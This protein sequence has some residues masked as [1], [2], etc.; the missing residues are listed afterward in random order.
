MMR[1]RQLLLEKRETIAR[2]WLEVVLATYPGSSAAI[3]G[4]EKDPFANP[5]GHGLRVGTEH[6]LALLLDDAELEDIGESLHGIMKIRA[7]QQFPP[8]RAVAF[9]FDLKGVVRAELGEAGADPRFATEL[10]ELDARVDRV[11]LM[12]FDAYVACREQIYQLRV[13]EVKRQVSWVVGKVNRQES[14]LELV[15]IES[16]SDGNGEQKQREDLR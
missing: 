15:Q 16:R 14:E 7:V 6:I 10:A 3:F 12:A 2:R 4:R 9:V 11:A 1:L 8:S 5:V 13:N